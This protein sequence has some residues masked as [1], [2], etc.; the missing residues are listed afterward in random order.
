[1]TK[2]F[3][4][5]FVTS[6]FAVTYGQYGVLPGVSIVLF[7]RWGCVAKYEDKCVRNCQFFTGILRSSLPMSFCLY[8]NFLRRTGPPRRQTGLNSGKTV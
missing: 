7:A 4:L 6:L 5:F 8:L 2:Q 3:L 1:M